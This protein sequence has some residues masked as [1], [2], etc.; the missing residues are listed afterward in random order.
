MPRVR[1]YS[2]VLIALVLSI[3]VAP[4]SKMDA[5][6]AVAAP[7]IGLLRNNALNTAVLVGDLNNDGKL[8]AVATDP[9]SSPAPVV[10]AALGQ[11]NGRFGAPIRTTWR[12]G[13]LATGHFNA[14]TFLDAVIMAVSPSAGLRL[15]PG[16]GDGT[17]ATAIAFP[18][19]TTRFFAPFALATDFTGDGET[20]FA[21]GHADEFE[22]NGVEIFSGHGDGTFGASVT[23]STGNNSQPYGATF[24]DFN[25]D[26]TLDIVAANHWSHSLSVFLNQGSLAFT[27]YDIPL[28]RQANAVVAADINGDR[29][30]DLVAAMSRDAGDDFFYTDGYAYIL[31]G[32]GTGTFAQPVKYETAAGAWEVV[33]ADLNRDGKPDVAT[34]N[35]S[36]T[37]GED[38]CGSL[39]DTVTILPGRSDFTFGPA[40]SFSLGDQRVANGDRFHNSVQSLRAADMNGDLRFD[41][42]TSWGAVLL[43]NSPD[44]NWGPS[45]TASA[46]Q[47]DPDTDEIRLMASANDVDQD[48]LTFSWTES[49]GQWIAPTASPCF[50]PDTLGVHT[51]TVTVDDGHGH[52]TSSSVTVDFGGTPTPYRPPTATIASPAGSEIVTAGR[53]YTMR[54]SVTPGSHPITQINVRSWLE[55]SPATAIAE[56]TGLPASATSCVWNSPGPISE[57]AHISVDMIDS[58][59]RANGVTSDRFSIRGASGGGGTLPYGWTAADVGNVA[60]AGSTTHNGFIYNGESLALSGSGADIWG[61][62]DEFRYAWRQ[63]TGNFEVVT[64]VTSVENVNQWTK[65]GLMVRT[66]ATD[67]ASPHVSIF[68]TPSKGVAFQRRT[69][70]GGTSVSTA[71]PALTAPVWLRMIRMGTVVK[72]FYRKNPTDTWTMLGQQ[73][74]S[75][76]PATVN[77]GLAVTSHADGS[78]ADASFTGV[79]T[80][81]LPELTARVIGAATGSVTWDGTTYTVKASGADIWGT[82]DAFVFVEMPIGDYRAITARVRV[83]GN[84]HQWTKA[85]VMIRETLSPDSRHADAIVSPAKG[86]A[87]QYRATPG[88]TSVSA[89]QRAGSAP[90]LLRIRRSENASGGPAAFDANYS[91]DGGLTWRAFCCG[92]SMSMNHLARIGI[93]VTSHNAG[94]E[95]TALI[96]DVRI[97]Q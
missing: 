80:A 90:I 24:A 50:R 66:A 63:M 22:N 49:G 60:A 45:V 42:I 29:H 51:F 93:A 14:D 28:D 16:R 41:L 6:A 88:G 7:A 36:A 56:C 44:P 34:A 4:E 82:S 74:I 87:L 17:F 37:V 71:T 11:G 9:W 84:V 35:R 20:D 78:V 43:N 85:G 75:G 62:A 2:V 30:M 92:A 61:T 76:W 52:T 89:D 69:Q 70:P 27:A 46:T 40:S 12:G 57:T 58:T 5:Q 77:V 81:P 79:W 32:N 53:P 8:D 91:T 55:T 68:A 95:T 19:S 13:V 94:V 15:L 18:G 31:R 59:G 33:V 86:I 73:T 72:A 25:D 23:L 38:V 48:M 96:D 10:I 67:P 65:A 26:G 3:S 54:W 97:E 1:P 83:L 47:P 64:R 21:V 39:W